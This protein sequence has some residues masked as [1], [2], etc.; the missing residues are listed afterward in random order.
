MLQPGGVVCSNL[1]SRVTLNDGNTMPWIGLGVYQS[2]PG[3]ETEDAVYI[4]LREGYRH[5][6]TAEYYENEESVGRA[7]S[8][9][10]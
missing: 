1:Q 7:I 10:V 9:F 3:N 6:D 5:I 2:K 4:A 8:R